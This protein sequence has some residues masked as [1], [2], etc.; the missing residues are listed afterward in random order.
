MRRDFRG[1]EQGGDPHS[2][3]EGHD[4]EEHA[5]PHEFT[6]AFLSGERWVD[7]AWKPGREVEDRAGGEKPG[8]D[9]P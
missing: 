2:H 3:G 8:R 7:M 6:S 9:M 5:G 4:G 1:V